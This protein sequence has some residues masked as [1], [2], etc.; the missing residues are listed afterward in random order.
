MNWSL[1]RQPI[2]A[3]AIN[4]ICRPPLPAFPD[5]QKAK[6]KTP[7]KGGGALRSRW[8]DNSGKIYEWD[9]QHG[10]VVMYNK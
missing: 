10:T 1:K 7:V 5:A 9:S 8:K 4:P 3:I 6:K 2:P